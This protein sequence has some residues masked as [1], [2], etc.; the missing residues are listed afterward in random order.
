VADQD[1]NI[2]ENGEVIPDAEQTTESSDKQEKL[3]EG[4]S[5][6]DEQDGEEQQAEGQ[7]DGES[8][9]TDEEVDAEREA[10]RERRRQE[11]KHKKEA[12]R[13]REDALKRELSSR[14]S[15]INDLTNRLSIIERK[16]SGMELS[17]IEAN[18][19]QATDAYNYF[20][21]QI[22]VA[23]AAGNHEAIAEATEKMILSRDRFNQLNHVKQQYQQKQQQ[24]APLDPRLTNHVNEW[25]NRN[26]WYDPDKRDEDS[27]L[28]SVIDKRLAAEGWNP[29]TPEYW[30]ELDVRLK[31]RLPHRYNSGYNGG[32][33]GSRPRSPVS[34]SG[35]ESTGSN[36]STQSYRL[37]AD[38]VSAL[39]DLG[40]VQ[41][42]PEFVESVKRYKEYDK[43]HSAAGQR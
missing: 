40:I 18:I 43:Q 20:K 19:K 6:S 22:A 33:G 36:T 8:E 27:E 32:N 30:Q 9:L 15:V 12:Q 26:P 2:D 4:Q 5:T 14:D 39:K 11:R 34:G 13:E 41:G 7:G 25:L 23:S 28:A 17:S 3:Q 38:R 1:L 42:T 24:P 10:I 16:S 21:N 31:K 35:R 29:T 37:S